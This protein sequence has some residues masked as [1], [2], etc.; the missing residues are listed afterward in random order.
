MSTGYTYPVKDGTI[1]DLPTFTA[2]LAASTHPGARVI[3]LRGGV[4][5]AG[6]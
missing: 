5:V 4:E 3:R 2:D 1:T 6:E